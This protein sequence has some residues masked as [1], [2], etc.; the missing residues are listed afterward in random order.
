MSATQRNQNIDY[1]IAMEMK[2]EISDSLNMFYQPLANLVVEADQDTR[3]IFNAMG[4]AVVSENYAYELA[5]AVAW[6]NNASVVL[7]TLRE[8][9]LTER[10][11]NRLRK[12]L[13]L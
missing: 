10:I 1:C 12:K 3:K 5:D 2:D 9:D 7:N 8:R 11:E 4:L 6:A 13:K